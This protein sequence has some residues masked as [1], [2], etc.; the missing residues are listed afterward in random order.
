MPDESPNKRKIELEDEQDSL[1]F[2]NKL[3]RTKLI[4]H[5]DLKTT[6]VEEMRKLFESRI[7]QLEERVKVLED[8]LEFNRDDDDDD[9]EKKKKK[10]DEKEDGHLGKD[11]VQLQDAETK[12]EPKVTDKSLGNNAPELPPRAKT[13]FGGSTFQFKP[14]ATTAAATTTANEETK[15]RNINEKEKEKEKESENENENEKES[16]SKE[17]NKYKESRSVPV[18]SRPVFGATT[19]FG[20]MAKFSPNNS[21]S[22]TSST[23]GSTLTSKTTNPKSPASKP[24]FGFGS[25]STFGNKSRFG[26]AFQESLKLKSFLDAD[27]TEATLESKNDTKS[28]NAPSLSGSGSVDNKPESQTSTTTKQFQQVD[29]NPVEQTTGEEDEKSLF[30]S[31]AKLFEL[32]LS[33]ISEGWRERGVGPLHLNQSKRDAKQVRIVMRSQGLLRVILNYRIVKNTEVMRGLEASLAPGKYLRLNSLNSEG[34]P[35]QYLVKFA[36][37][38]LRDELV[39]KIDELKTEM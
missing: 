19:S 27:S 22:T 1:S 32:E 31:N 12:Q 26:N 37:E 4:G 5:E 20:N 6:V 21:D 16:V 36:N 39:S 10:E 11:N 9:D 15:T 34:K 38:K 29:L 13:T 25:G 18:S 14:N 35:I 17:N 8:I 7:V 24:A 23:T 33:K 28:E 30:T 3:K 2:D